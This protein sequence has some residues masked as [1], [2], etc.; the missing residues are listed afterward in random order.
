[1]RC[2]YPR[3]VGFKAD[4]RTIC[5]SEKERS[6]QFASFQ[7]LCSKCIECRLE[8]ARQWAVR[9][10]Q[11][12]RMHRENSFITLTYSDEHLGDGRLRYKDFQLFMKSLRERFC[13]REIPMAVTGEYGDEKKRPHWHALVFNFWPPD[14]VYKYKSE[15]GDTCY[16]SEILQDVWK[17]GMVEVGSLTFES[18][19]YVMRYAAKKLVHGNDQDHEFHPISKKSSKYAIGKSFIERYWKDVFSKGCCKIGRYSE[20]GILED[21][22]SCSIPRYYEKWLKDKKPEVWRAYVT[23]VKLPQMAK[24]ESREAEE[25]RLEFARN[26]ERNVYRDGCEIKK[27]KVRE[28]II[29]QKFAQLQERLKGDL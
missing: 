19:G 11:E 8:Y 26:L 2:L 14:A 17:R 28:R 27:N 5:W 4:G 9:S 1:M 13:D 18:A 29:N 15:R 10:V 25:R 23:E 20:S 12:A 24:A 6:K 3:T 16:S 22:V 7:L 21:T